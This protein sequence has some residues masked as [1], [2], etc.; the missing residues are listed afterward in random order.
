MLVQVPRSLASALT[1]PCPLHH[2]RTA[3]VLQRHR[4]TATS[5]IIPSSAFCLAKR[6]ASLV[7]D[8]GLCMLLNQYQ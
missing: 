1:D 3:L 8:I 5:S 6:L 4:R 2:S 7:L